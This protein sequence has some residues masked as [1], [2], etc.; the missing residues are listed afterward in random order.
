MKEDRYQVYAYSRP[1]HHMKV[2]T[3]NGFCFLGGSRHVKLL[4]LSTSFFVS[5]PIEPTLC[6]VAPQSKA[7]RVSYHME[8]SACMS[9]WANSLCVVLAVEGALVGDPL[10]SDFMCVQ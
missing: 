1:G 8:T 7:I 5:N 6:S 2:R 3:V 9:C 4:R 10:F